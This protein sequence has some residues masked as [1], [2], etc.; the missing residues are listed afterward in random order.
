MLILRYTTVDIHCRDRRYEWV[1]G[2]QSTVTAADS[3]DGGISVLNHCLSWSKFVN[4]HLS[5]S[6]QWFNIYI[7]R[8]ECLV[9]AMIWIHVGR[10][11]RSDETDVRTT[12]PVRS[13]PIW[14]FCRPPS[15]DRCPPRLP[16]SRW[17]AGAPHCRPTV[18]RSTAVYLAESG[19]VWFQS[20]T[21]RHQPSSVVECFPG[22][23]LAM[24][25]LPV[26]TDIIDNI[27]SQFVR[28]LLRNKLRD[29]S[30]ICHTFW[31]KFNPLPLCYK[32]SHMADP[33]SKICHKPQPPDSMHLLT[34]HQNFHNH[35]YLFIYV[36]FYVIMHACQSVLRTVFSFHSLICLHRTITVQFIKLVEFIHRVKWL[37]FTNTDR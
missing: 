15:T 33:L 20:P 24:A 22:M 14:L 13:T 9:E 16:T 28:L 6:R 36:C 18:P 19:H 26:T 10:Y 4:I 37:S 1:G 27:W 35:T 25:P 31:T 12:L 17:P 11:H 7:T 32:L 5:H 21:F 30:K 23:H 8:P 2:I 3:C 34:L 29:H